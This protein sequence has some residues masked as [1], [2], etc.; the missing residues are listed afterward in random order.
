MAAISK[1]IIHV[2]IEDEIIEKLNEKFYEIARK[3]GIKWGTKVENGTAGAN[4]EW[5]IAK[6]F[7]LHTIFNKL[8]YDSMFH[9]P[10][11]LKHY[12]EEE[13]IE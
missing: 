10:E 12:D 5:T 1:D 4:F 3:H 13:D 9:Y 7:F 8:Q 11:D 2:E 6:D